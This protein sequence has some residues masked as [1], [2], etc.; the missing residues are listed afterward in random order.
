MLPPQSHKSP[1]TVHSSAVEE[2]VCVLIDNK[3]NLVGGCVSVG[4]C[5]WDKQSG[6]YG[7]RC[8]S[9]VLWSAAETGRGQRGF[10]S[11]LC[12]Q[13]PACDTHTHLLT[14]VCIKCL[15]HTRTYMDRNVCKMRSFITREDKWTWDEMMKAR[16]D[17]QWGGCCWLERKALCWWEWCNLGKGLSENEAIIQL[18][19]TGSRPSL[20]GTHPVWMFVSSLIQDNYD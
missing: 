19:R 17:R 4:A 3:S 8:T 1:E 13:P 12:Q 5:P 20:S 15:K 6:M 18:N 2:E 14:Y 7:C 10:V 9:H 11:K 16:H